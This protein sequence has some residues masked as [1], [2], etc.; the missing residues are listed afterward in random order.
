MWKKWRFV[1]SKTSDQCTYPLKKCQ[2][3][4]V[5]NDKT[6]QKAGFLLYGLWSYSLNINMQIVS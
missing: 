5:L 1:N 4:C 2:I 3:K 6:P